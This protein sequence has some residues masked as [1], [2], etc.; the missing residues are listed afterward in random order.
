MVTDFISFINVMLHVYHFSLD[1]DII[2]IYI[3]SDLY[4]TPL[5][6]LIKIMLYYVLWEIYCIEFLTSYVW[7]FNNYDEDI[8]HVQLIKINFY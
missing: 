3:F 7:E 4:I 2:S 8:L 6:F 1:N 5:F